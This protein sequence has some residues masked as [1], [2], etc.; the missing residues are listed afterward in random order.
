M[1]TIYRIAIIMLTNILSGIIGCIIGAISVIVIE[2]K[3]VERHDEHR[4]KYRYDGY[5][6]RRHDNI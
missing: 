2:N 1:K 4:E 3:A 6:R 5:R